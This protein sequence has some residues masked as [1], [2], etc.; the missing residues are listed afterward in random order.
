MKNLLP[1]AIALG[2]ATFTACKK[3]DNPSTEPSITDINEIKVPEGFLWESSHDVNINVSVT[4]ERFGAALHAIT[5]YDGNPYNGGN[6]LAKGSASTA[7]PYENTL[8][9]SRQVKEVYIVKKSP[10]G[11]WIMNKMDVSGASAVISFSDIDKTQLEKGKSAARVTAIDCNSGCT[12]TITSS[13]NNVNL[14]SGDV[15]CITGNN[16][17]VNF[18][19]VNN[20]TVR[21]CGS[22]VTLQNLNLNGSSSLLV[23]STGSVNLS[24]FNVNSGTA[25]VENEGT[26]NISGSTSIAGNFSNSGTYNCTGDF[27][28]NSNTASFVNYGT[29]NVS[30]SF[31]NGTPQSVSATNNG[32]IN[33][34][35]HFQ[36]NTSGNFINNCSLM[37]SGNYNQTGTVKN[38]K[39]IKVSGT[40]TL[41]SGELELYNT[42][43]FD[44]NSFIANVPVRGYGSTSLVKIA[45][46]ITINGNGEFNGNLQ[47]CSNASINN[48]KLTGGATTG[49]SLYIPTSN[50]NSVG[51]G[52]PSVVDTDNDGVPDNTDEYPNDPTKAYNNYYPSSTGMATAAFEDQWPAKGDFD[53]NDLVISYRY[54]IVT[55]AT[56]NVV[57]VNG[58]YKLHATGGSYQNGFGVQF[59]VN[60]SAVSGLTSGT[61]EQN[62][63]K[64]VVLVFGNMRNEMVNWNT[65]Q[66]KPTSAPVDYSFTF[67]VANGPSIN[68]FG[69]SGYNPFI[70]NGSDS[71]GRETHLAGYTPTDLANTSLYGTQDDN[72][73]IA[74]NRYYVTGSGLPYAI[75]IPVT[76][77]QYPFERV[78]ITQAYLRFG[79]WAQS[80]G[81][82]YTDWYSNTATGYRN[83]SNIYAP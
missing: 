27:N 52:T 64:A 55:N 60:R 21:V 58:T 56:N 7:K 49:C 81:Q 38:Y 18:S 22:N 36:H 42:A 50:C 28:L 76:P 23:S 41:N 63:T 37:I 57:E 26:L 2:L 66:G 78:D 30:G 34:S 73:S 3:T 59:P 69:L 20:A 32:Q 19:G 5:V 1:I 35:G 75:E 9:V 72:S 80:G 47:V 82:S 13:T 8:R 40:T 53:L 16:I 46:S 17:T 31:N 67:T 79:N 44:A 45:G 83:T 51:N 43:M 4:D 61:L 70:W 24:N 62:Q 12:S 68:N 74:N 48:S 25:I 77:F 11:S 65:E 10:D 6:L 33:V 14:N 39:L 15:L 71:R 54:K 29:M